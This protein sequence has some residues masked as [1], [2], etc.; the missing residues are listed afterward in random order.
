MKKTTL[1]SIKKTVFL[2]SR[3]IFRLFYGRHVW[4]ICDR[5]NEAG[6]NGEIFFEYLQNKPIKS[7]FAIS[8]SSPEYDRLKQIGKVIDYDSFFHKF[9]LIVCD[10]HISSQDNHMRNHI[11]TPQ[12][13]LQHGVINNDLHNYINSFAHDNLYIHASAAPEAESL[14]RT[15]YNIK[16]GHVLL[17]GMPRYDILENDP[18]KLILFAFTWRSYL[19]I[20]DSKSFFESDYFLNIK[21]I[22]TDK[23]IIETAEAKGYKL[24]Y[25]VHPVYKD[26]CKCLDLPKCIE[27]YTGSY[28]DFFKYG[29]LLITDY[30][31]VAFDFS[32]LHKPVLYYQFD[33]DTFYHSNIV[34]KGY[35]DVNTMG[36]GP[37]TE[38]FETFKKEFINLINN[39]C[40]MNPE[41]VER[42]DN[43]FAFRDKNNCKRVYDEIYSILYKTEV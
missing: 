2:I 43:F 13:F 40:K 8:K 25:K 28:K 33:K 3:S 42:A 4:L 15:P 21:N 39:D 14:E 35:F 6:D 9:L 18:Q 26:F 23:D 37:V 1:D 16:E 27:E 22:F 19:N 7:Y 10:A 24:C 12:F 17:T 32:Y 36:F 5:K 30:S 31:S 38:T 29:N 11:E 41:Y 20:S 34:E